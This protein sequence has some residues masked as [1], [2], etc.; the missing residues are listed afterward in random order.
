MKQRMTFLM[1]MAGSMLAG[2]MASFAAPAP[3]SKTETKT[4]RLVEAQK[5]LALTVETTRKDYRVNEPVSLRVTLDRPAYLY[6]YNRGADGKSAFIYPQSGAA[7]VKQV[8]GSQVMRNLLVADQP[9]DEELVV[10]ASDKPFDI[11]EF[12]DEAATLSTRDLER[13]LSAAGLR[14]AG[15]A[16]M[17]QLPGVSLPQAIVLKIGTAADAA[18]AATTGLALVTTDKERYKIGAPVQLVYGTN[19]PGYV[20]LF[21]V[22]PSG[23]IDPLLSEKFEAPG[24]KTR[25]AN[26]DAPGGDQAIL[27]IWSSDGKVTADRLRS[28]GIDGNPDSAEKSLR[29]RD[30]AAASTGTITAR[31]IKVEE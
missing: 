22:Y 27:A 5:P 23:D 10:F 18:A 26:T 15:T 6:I 28:A 16:R 25:M 31:R 12:Q 4:V 9:G 21:M 14:V 11:A 1:L 19:K 7:E 20:Q 24:L 13:K 3:D 17:A 29:L 30:P 8:A 2:G